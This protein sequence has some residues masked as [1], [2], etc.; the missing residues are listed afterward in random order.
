MDVKPTPTATPLPRPT[1]TVPLGAAGAREI[2]RGSSAVN[3][4]A[5]TFDCG[6]TANGTAEI[7]AALCEADVSVT[8]FMIGDWVRAHHELAREIATRHEFVSHSNTHPDYRDLSDAEIATDLEGAERAFI[9]VTGK[10]TRPLWRAPRP[11]PRAMTACWPAAARAGWPLHIFWTFGSDALGAVTG[12]SGDW[13]DFT[14]SRW[15]QPAARGSPWERGGPRGA[16]RQRADAGGA[17][18]D[19]A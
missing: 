18:D 12:D 6:G 8:F 17:A 16:L 15:R 9:E 7:L 11:R 4:I 14:H 19:P 10:T 5:L 13:R 2:E 1:P 3:S